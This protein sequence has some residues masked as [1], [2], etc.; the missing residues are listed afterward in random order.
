[1]IRF[2]YNEVITGSPLNIL[3]S[4]L[5]PLYTEALF[6][7]LR[8]YNLSTLFEI[9]SE[10]QQADYILLPHNYFQINDAGFID[11]YIDVAKRYNKKLFI[12]AYGDTTAPITIPNSIVVRTS[13]YKTAKQA[14]EI[15]MPAYVEDLWRTGITSRT[16]SERPVVGFVGWA[17][18]N[19][20]WRYIKYALIT[21]WQTII[22]TITGSKRILV[23]RQGIYYR[24][25][26]MSLLSGSRSLICNFILRSTYSAH[27]RTVGLPLDQVRQEYV[28]TIS[29]S[30]FFLAPKGDGNYSLRFFEVLSLGRIPVLIDTDMELPFED[31]IAYDRFVVRVPFDSL[32]QA[33]HL[34][35]Q[36]YNQLSDTEYQQRQIEAR[37]AFAEHLNIKSFF[38]HVFKRLVI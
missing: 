30:D 24:R 6:Q 20:P 16:K 28:H 14:N 11:R 15:I 26:V 12:V 36:F 22:G 19:S 8:P 9:V 18:F 34:I 27:R 31:T 25:K 13:Q 29:A 35:V 21:L 10:P 17:A 1:M 38:E 7:S 33:E 32:D 23:G 4:D 2:Y 37:Q 5:D 3:L